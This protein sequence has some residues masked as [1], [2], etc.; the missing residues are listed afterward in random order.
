MHIDVIIVNNANDIIFGLKE[1]KI[2]Y[3]KNTIFKF[4][5]N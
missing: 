4:S 2:K 1:N 5:T 3:K